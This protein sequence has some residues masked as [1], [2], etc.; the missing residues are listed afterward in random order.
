MVCVY[1]LIEVMAQGQ[2]FSLQYAPLADDL[3]HRPTK[4]V[5]RR[6]GISIGLAQQEM[7][8]VL[9]LDH[10][11]IARGLCGHQEVGILAP[12]AP[13]V[14][15]ADIGLVRD[16]LHGIPECHIDNQPQKING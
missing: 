2:N 16:L 9:D 15:A 10:G 5:R 6:E 3:S 4:F 7:L 11:E 13:D 12:L 8:V 1:T 14:L